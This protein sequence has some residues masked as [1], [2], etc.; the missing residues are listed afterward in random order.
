MGSEYK[1]ILLDEFDWAYVNNNKSYNKQFI[2]NQFKRFDINNVCSITNMLVFECGRKFPIKVLN[3]ILVESENSFPI[4]DTAYIQVDNNSELIALE[5]STCIS[6][7]GLGIRYIIK[8][9][10]SRESIMCN[11]CA[12]LGKLWIQS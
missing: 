4:C 11:D 3:D 2:I 1:L 10:L 5:C 7:R 12:G 8:E 9:G 6:C